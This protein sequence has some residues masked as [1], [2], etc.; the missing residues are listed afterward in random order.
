M[1]KTILVQNEDDLLTAQALASGK[2]YYF[3]LQYEASQIP[4]PCLSFENNIPYIVTSNQKLKKFRLNLA[5]WLNHFNHHFKGENLLLK[6]I[7]KGKG[8]KIL[9]TTF[10][11]GIDSMH[12]LSAGHTLS[13]VEVMPVLAFMAQCEREQDHLNFDIICDH[14]HHYLKTQAEEFDI[15]YLDP[16]FRADSKKKG[17]SKKEMQILDLLGAQNTQPTELMKLSLEKAKE[18]VVVKRHPKSPLLYPCPDHQF[19]GKSVRFDIYSTK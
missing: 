12:F 14:S 15:I 6:S 5:F 17:L 9:D 8:K 16:M 4:A 7:G 11:V 1:V 18:R 2:D 3:T 19:V 10:G 13:S